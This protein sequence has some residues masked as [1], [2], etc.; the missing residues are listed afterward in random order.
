M[1]WYFSQALPTVNIGDYLIQVGGPLGIIII[2][3]LVAL[4]YYVRK[5]DKLQ[6]QLDQEKDKRL[7]DA[8]EF[9]KLTREPFE[10]F[11]DFVRNLYD[12]SNSRNKGV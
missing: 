4:V 6:N 11:T 12:G 1:T 7:A 9:S 8:L 2:G 5:S 3:L 10:R